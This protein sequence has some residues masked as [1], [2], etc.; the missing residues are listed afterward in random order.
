M[1]PNA[2]GA[3]ASRSSH[4]PFSPETSIY[5]VLTWY[6][7]I[8][9]RLRLILLVALVWI[10]ASAL[11]SCLR[12]QNAFDE[13]YW[14]TIDSR[15]G[16]A[17]MKMHFT[18]LTLASLLSP[19]KLNGVDRM[20]EIP[21]DELPAHLGFLEPVPH[22]FDEW[23]YDYRYRDDADEAVASMSWWVTDCE[24]DDL[25]CKMT[26]TAE[27]RLGHLGGGYDR[28]A[29]TSWT[30]DAVGKRLTLDRAGLCSESVVPGSFDIKDRCYSA[31][32]VDACL[33]A[34]GSSYDEFAQSCYDFLVSSLVA[35]YL[36]AAQSETRFSI[37]DIGPI[38]VDLYSWRDEDG[39]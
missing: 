5:P 26:I 6:D 29:E 22:T 10:V 13:V 34:Q 14:S 19:F 33:A 30:Y 20:D 3:S 36:S 7:K 11:F 27:Q 2:S 32:E 28:M 8:R 4:E 39:A 9:R 37:S 18:P 21:H 12:V 23:V 31:S 1:E 25:E 24:F 15:A 17:A 16:R 35:G 38:K